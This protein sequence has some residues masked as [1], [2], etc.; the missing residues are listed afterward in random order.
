MMLTHTWID[1][2]FGDRPDTGKALRDA[3]AGA[4]QFDCGPVDDIP[5]G[6]GREFCEAR[7][8][9]PNTLLQFETPSS[10]GA[11]HAMV[12]W[13]EQ[14]DGS[15]QIICAQRKKNKEW[16]SVSPTTVTKNEDGS[17]HYHRIGYD[18]RNQGFAT[19]M[20]ARALNLFY[21]LGCSN[22]ETADNPAQAALNKKRAKSGK[23]PVLEYKTLV[24]KIDRLRTSGQTDGGS[25]ASPRVHLRRGHVRQLETGRR[26]W[27]QACVVGSTNGMILKDYR[28]TTAGA[29]GSNAISAVRPAE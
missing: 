4:V 25:H 10:P 17:F 18:E 20:H 3:I 12:L 28:I 6:K 5:I 16:L 8:P 23:Y 1:Q 2:Y 13:R 22:V 9:Y 24:L 7:S 11:S 29:V 19:L 27:V 15:V 26:V 21:I 14:P